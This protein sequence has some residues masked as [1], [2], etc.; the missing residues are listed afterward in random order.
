MIRDELLQE[1]GEIAPAP[2][3]PIEVQE[4]QARAKLL[5]T[6]LRNIGA[7]LLLLSAFAFMLQRWDGMEHLTRYFSFLTFTVV[8]AGA[9]LFFGLGIKESKGARTL[10][11]VV[12]VIVPVHFAQLGALLFSKFGNIPDPSI[13]PKYLLWT[14]PTAYAAATTVGIALV[15]LLPILYLAYS[16]LDRGLSKY[17]VGAAVI[18][19]V[20]LLIPTRDPN[21]VMALV[22]LTLGAATY[23]DQR[24]LSRARFSTFE[25]K[26]S[27]A[28]IFIPV[29]LL[30][31]RQ[32][33]L[34]SW[35]LG[36]AAMVLAMIAA[37]LFFVVPATTPSLVGETAQLLSVIPTAVSWLLVLAEFDFGLPVHCAETLP[38]AGAGLGVAYAGMGML[39]PNLRRSF[40]SLAG[41][42]L[43][44]TSTL[45]LNLHHTLLASAYSLVAVTT[46]FAGSFL[47]GYNL[48]FAVACIAGM[49]SLVT[50]C[51]I[52]IEAYPFNLWIALG[53]TGILSVVAASYLER[54]LSKVVAFIRQAHGSLSQEKF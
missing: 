10:L 42:V 38:L 43:L 39:S 31:G 5:G 1:A 46:V 24:L 48:C 27:R 44:A 8:M 28:T 33:A 40:F 9:G 34:Y 20:P 30:L 18:A 54:H 37:T 52:I 15:V 23:I 36:L 13:Y 47:L 17:L 29:L 32:L 6:L 11:A 21:L 7:A 16:V 51:K 19:N 3:P 49:H 53:V 14:A 41:L 35:S 2:V 45:E 50:H 22:C 12:S 4:S 26:L 25:S